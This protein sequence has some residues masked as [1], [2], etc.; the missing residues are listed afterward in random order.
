MP[1]YRTLDWKQP[2]PESCQGGAISVGNFDGVH[3]GH[4]SLIDVLR[5]EARIVAGPAVAI[6]FDPHPLQL[7]APDRFQPVLTDPAERARLLSENGADEVV[8][9]HTTHDLLQL[10]PEDFAGRILHSG[11]RAKS[12]VEGFNFRFGHDRAGD[13]EQLRSLC[14]SL[15]MAFVGVPAF[16]F[17]GNSVSSSRV[18][19]VLEVGDVREAAHLLGRNYSIH[20]TVGT[21]QRRGRNL[22]FPTANL[23]RVQTLLPGDGVYAVLAE[24]D[25]QY[26]LGAANIGPNPTFGE[27][28]RKIEVHLLDFNG[29]L[30]G[31]QLR[32]SFVERIRDTR[33]FAN[34]DELVEQI[35][36]DV[37]AVRAMSR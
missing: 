10:S 6:S 28:A 30:Y 4:S 31:R 19:R 33:S 7:L 29:D 8:L 37:A 3:L 23:E 2:P 13:V 32:V 27:Q 14:G 9:L 12:I 34:V 36:Q 22:G 15:G 17:E 16:L 1:P 24:C 5:K 21:G 25:G 18:R 11:F 26:W 20:G 35:Q